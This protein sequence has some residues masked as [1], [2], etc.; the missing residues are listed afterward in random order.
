M[1]EQGGGAAPGWY[2]QG[3]GRQR[4]WD[5]QQWTEHFS[6]PSTSTGPV[7]T[8]PAAPKK[9]GFG[10]GCLIATAVALLLGLGSCIALVAVSGGDKSTP[11]AQSTTTSSVPKSAPSPG[12][13]STSA[14]APSSDPG[15]DPDTIGDED[16]PVTITEGQPF[17]I[18]GFDY[19]GGWSVGDPMFGMTID[20][21]KV[22]NN[23]PRKDSAFVEVKFWRGTEVLASINCTS[24][25]IAPGT[26][27]TLN[28]I[29][30]DKKPT[31]YDRLT[32]NDMF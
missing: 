17:T 25:D 22:T 5:G 6:G 24:D 7:G 12:A 1:S 9:R 18:R 8:A 19:A 29:T 31:D 10:T 2:P 23:R 3:D 20:G 27:V 21:L 26:T 4:Y 14:P 16:H 30:G 32:I 28:C 13:A 11:S 15:V